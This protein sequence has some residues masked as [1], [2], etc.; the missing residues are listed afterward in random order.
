MNVPL[1]FDASCNNCDRIQKR[2]AKASILGKL[3][4]WA[5]KRINECEKF[6]SRDS[7]LNTAITV[8]IQGFSYGPATYSSSKQFHIRSMVEEATPTCFWTRVPLSFTDGICPTRKFRTDRIMF[9]QEGKALG[10]GD[11]GQVLVAASFLQTGRT[12]ESGCASNRNFVFFRYLISFDAL[13]DP[14]ILE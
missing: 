1:V 7:A 11:K 6:T 13:I 9:D 4:D 3:S 14:Q 10:Y 8:V 5:S 2:E 12:N